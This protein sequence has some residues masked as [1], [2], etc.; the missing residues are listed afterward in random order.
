MSKQRIKQVDKKFEDT[1]NNIRERFA[2]EMGLGVTFKDTTKMI[3][4]LLDDMDFQIGKKDKPKSKVTEI[5][6]KVKRRKKR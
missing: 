6:M 3:G 1:I 4:K 5:K 2:K